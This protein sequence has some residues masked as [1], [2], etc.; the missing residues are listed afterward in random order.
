MNNVETQLNN[1]QPGAVRRVHTTKMSHV[2]EKKNLKSI[3]KLELVKKPSTK[4]NQLN[5]LTFQNKN[6]NFYSDKKTKKMETMSM[7][8][9][10]CEL[11]VKI[12]NKNSYEKQNSRAVNE[13][14]VHSNFNS[15]E[16]IENEPETQSLNEGKSF[17]ENCKIVNFVELSPAK[18]CF[19]L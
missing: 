4:A 12:S 15:Y 13:H 1:S 14:Y 8:Y 18:K 2:P 7:I 19:G 10:H 17:I 11:E 9:S 3:S 5:Y 6:R 16:S